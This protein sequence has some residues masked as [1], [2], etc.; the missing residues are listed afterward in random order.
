MQVQ[1]SW[2]GVTVFAAYCLLLSGAVSRP[3]WMP[4]AE[5]VATV[6]ILFALAGFL[7]PW[8]TKRGF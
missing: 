4:I 2:R 8:V 3:S 5:A 7:V 1:I 6:L